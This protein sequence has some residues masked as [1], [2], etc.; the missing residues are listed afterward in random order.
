MREIYQAWFHLDRIVNR[1]GVCVEVA[2]EMTTGLFG[3]VKE[4]EIAVPINVRGWANV[5]Q[6][7]EPC[8]AA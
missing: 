7:N 3:S 5:V 8:M 2:N 1:G 4:V 6:Q